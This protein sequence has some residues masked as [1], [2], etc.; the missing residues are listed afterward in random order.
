MA[1]VG[2]GPSRRNSAVG[3]FADD[4]SADEAEVEDGDADASEDVSDEN[5]ESDTSVE[6]PTSST[7][8]RVFIKVAVVCDPASVPLDYVSWN[9]H[10]SKPQE[11]AAV[12]ADSRGNICD[13]VP[14]DKLRDPARLTAKTISPG[15]EI[16]DLLVFE[17]PGG[18]F[19]HLQLVLPYAALGID[20]SRN[21]YAAFQITKTTLNYPPGGNVA[22]G[23]G[24]D[25]KIRPRDGSTD[26]EW[27]M[28]AVHR[29]IR[30]SLRG[31]GER[32]PPVDKDPGTFESPKA[33]RTPEAREDAGDEDSPFPKTGSIGGDSTPSGAGP[34]I[35]IPPSVDDINQQIRDLRGGNREEEKK[36]P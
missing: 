20:K 3:R 11:T 4:S 24:A 7:P 1:P 19:E 17:I 34:Q 13:L 14:Y 15:Q 10:G 18:P 35:D 23:P 12:L 33:D 28:D 8:R 5:A 26:D 31:D 16:A 27:E 9:G 21:P 2:P 6:T 36:E 30:E 22:H 32:G 25:F 29:G